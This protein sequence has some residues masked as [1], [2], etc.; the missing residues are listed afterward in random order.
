[1]QAQSCLVP[2]QTPILTRR[3]GG[4]LEGGE[5]RL[6]FCR[7]KSWA[8]LDAKTQTSITNSS[9]NS[10]KSALNSPHDTIKHPHHVGTSDRVS[11]LHLTQSSHPPPRPLHPHRPRRPHLPD[12][13]VFSTCAGPCAARNFLP[14]PARGYNKRLCAPDLLHRYDIDIQPWSYHRLCR[15]TRRPW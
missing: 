6:I 15:R 12:P 10:L 11:S 5:S 1:M 7:R 13:L 4:R 9:Y 8:G 2:C 3:H 14:P